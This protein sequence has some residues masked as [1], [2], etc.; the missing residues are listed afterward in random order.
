MRNYFKEDIKE[1]NKFSNNI[2]N[3]TFKK[4]RVQSARNKIVKKNQDFNN[5][6]NEKLNQNASEKKII[7]NENI[8]DNEENPILNKLENENVN[9]EKNKEAIPG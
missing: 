7:V 1:R 2:K 9:D 3:N 4:K 8:S 6:D 5:L